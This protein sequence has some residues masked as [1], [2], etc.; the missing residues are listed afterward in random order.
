MSEGPWNEE[1]G[2]HLECGLKL[3]PEC[4]GKIGEKIR[5]L[6]DRLELLEP[7][8]KAARKYHEIWHLTLQRE[9]THEQLDATRINLFAKLADIDQEH[10]REQSPED[11]LELLEPAVEALRAIMRDPY[12][13]PFCDEG[14]L[15]KPNIPG[16]EHEE[17]CGY[18]LA[19]RALA[20]L[21]GGR[22]SCTH[23]LLPGAER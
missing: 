4:Q 20:A 9:A 14:K 7:A 22:A 1:L 12:G 8:V 11:R 17:D 6:K 3:C 18:Y 23:K 16:K 21:D 15:R 2:I 10:A 13:C 5:T 19:E